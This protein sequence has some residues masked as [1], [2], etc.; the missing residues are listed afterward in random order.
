MEIEKW[1]AKNSKATDDHVVIDLISI[2]KGTWCYNS[3]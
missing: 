3:V 2:S 1:M